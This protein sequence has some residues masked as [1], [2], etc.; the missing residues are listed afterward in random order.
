MNQIK[1]TFIDEKSFKDWT[2]YFTRYDRG[3]SMKMLSVYYNE[4]K[5]KFEKYE[6]KKYSMLD[7]K[8]MEKVLDKIKES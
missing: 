5:G 6:V 2:I 4:V 3:K 1:N 7:D 8:V